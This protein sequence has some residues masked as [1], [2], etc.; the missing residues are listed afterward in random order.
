MRSQYAETLRNIV[1]TSNLEFNDGRRGRVIGVTSSRPQEGK[2]ITSLNIACS[3]AAAGKSVCVIDSDPHMAGF[4][5][6]VGAQS[7]AG[8][9]DILSGSL[10]WEE[11][12]QTLPSTNIK[13]IQC[14]IPKGFNHGSEMLASSKMSDLIEDLKARFDVLVL[15]LAPMGPVIDARVLMGSL[16]QVV[17]VAE[18]GI[19][20]ISLAHGI[21]TGDRSL[22]TKLLGVV[23]N[24]VDMDKI[25]DYASDSDSATYYQEYNAYIN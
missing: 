7:K 11:V 5:R 2:S 1:L 6:I 21:L 4:T 3:F 13:M 15:D 14:I 8:L 16:D 25:G 23:L 9:L 19:T 10:E 22:E 12:L 20:P 17:F 24:K 18:W